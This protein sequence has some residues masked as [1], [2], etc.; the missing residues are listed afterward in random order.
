[1]LLPVV[2]L[3]VLNQSANY[4]LL[5]DAFYCAFTLCISMKV[6][7]AKIQLLNQS[8]IRGDFDLELQDFKLRMMRQV[9]NIL[10][11]FLAFSSIYNQ[12]KAHNMLA[13]MFDPHFKNMKIIQDFM[14]CA[15]DAI[16]I[17][18]NYDVNIVCLLL[19]QVFFH[20]NPIRAIT[21]QS[22]IVEDDDFFLGILYQMMM[23]SCS[24]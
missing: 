23:Q 11:L 18:T 10:S 14:G 17:V 19:L 22:I 21:H 12:A 3:C 9:I 24:H 1:M 15:H 5:L 6:D 13:T 7:L 2:K 20:L 16:Q 8:L 4:W